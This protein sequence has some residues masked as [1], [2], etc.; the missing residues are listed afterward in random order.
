MYCKYIALLYY[1]LKLD[2]T[3]DKFIRV[4]H[5]MNFHL[6][7]FNRKSSLAITIRLIAATYVPAYIYIKCVCTYVLRYLYV[8]VYSKGETEVCVHTTCI[9]RWH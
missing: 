9:M 4:E 6:G 7:C 1:L 8:T 5:S 2:Y 3:Y